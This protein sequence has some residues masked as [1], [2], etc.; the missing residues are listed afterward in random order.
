[1]AEERTPAGR[2]IKLGQYPDA[3]CAFVP[4]PLPPKIE[5]DSEMA[6]LLVE[7]DGALGELRGLARM[8]PNP[9]P[10]STHS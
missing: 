10:L 2:Y 4:D 3:V 7:A 5:Y 6:N 1:M 8:V 9:D